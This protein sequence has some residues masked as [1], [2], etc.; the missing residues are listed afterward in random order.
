MTTTQLNTLENSLYTLID[1]FKKQNKRKVLPFYLS[2][3]VLQDKI[4]D[5]VIEG[6][7]INKTNRGKNSY[8]INEETAD[9]AIET[10][11]NLL[12][13]FTLDAPNISPSSSPSHYNKSSSIIPL[14]LENPATTTQNKQNENIKDTDNLTDETYNQNQAQQLKE[15]VVVQAEE[16]MNRRFETEFLNVKIKMRK[17][18][19]QFI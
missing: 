14:S 18:G 10:T 2:K 5:L 19:F 17:T 6:E 8:W 9:T 1:K 15:E 4:D 11:V 16:T 3:D 7:I 12:H 13:N